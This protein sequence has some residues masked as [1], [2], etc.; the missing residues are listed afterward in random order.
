M[1]KQMPLLAA[2][3]LSVAVV[4]AQSFF[5]STSQSKADAETVAFC[6]L[7]T[8]PDKYDGKEVRF[9][10]KHVSTFEVSAFIHSDC[11]DTK[12]RAWVEFDDSS[13]NHFTKP[14]ILRKVTEEVYCC[15][16]SGSSLRE[17]EMLVT[18]VFHKSRK[19]GYGHGNDYCFMFTVKGVH[20]IGPTVII[21]VP[22]FDGT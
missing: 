22:G 7:L 1:R 10:A 5:S 12:K 16:L 6:D 9:R 18:A 14:E 19:Q 13:V 11:R 3:I 15:L 8:E 21:K 20:E 2:M 4:S 17:T